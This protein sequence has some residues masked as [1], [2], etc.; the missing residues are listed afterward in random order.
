MSV[1]PQKSVNLHTH[2]D[3]CDHAT[4][5]VADYVAYARRAGLKVLGMTEHAPVP[6]N[7]ISCNMMYEDLPRYVSTV[8]SQDSPD[9]R[10]LLGCECDFEPVL[11]NY[12]RDELLG[13][14]GFDYLICSIHLYFD[15]EQR[16]MCFASKSRDFS[17]YLSDYVARYCRALESGIFLFG[18]H[19]DLFRAS[20]LP[21]DENARL[22]SRDIIQC[23]VEND[24][25]LEINGCGLRKPQVHA[26]EGLR[27]PY[28]TDEFYALA[29]D[30]GALI[31]L[32][33]DAHQPSLVA[34]QLTPDGISDTRAMADRLGITPVSWS[35]EGTG[36]QAIPPEPAAV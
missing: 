16:A 31:C 2:S 9:L 20:Y 26:P 25:P 7:P 15:F 3:F 30:M 29:R 17:R 21:W 28:S 23:A 13:K 24:I 27:C 4:G 11:E 35:I 12:Y 1:Y 5:S 34:G 14:Y 36:A 32:S 22:A 33:S 10:V 6:G 18:C 8:R 19:P